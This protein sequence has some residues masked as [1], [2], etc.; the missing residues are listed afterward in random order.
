M[1]EH[2]KRAVRSTLP[3]VIASGDAVVA[4]LCVAST[5][6]AV[7]VL[8][9]VLRLGSPLHHLSER[10]LL[11]LLLW[12]ALAGLSSSIVIGALV[13]VFADSTRRDDIAHRFTLALVPA[14]V[15]T[16]IAFAAT[17]SNRPILIV[18]ALA[19]G[20]TLFCVASRSASQR[21]IAMLA[22]A[23]ATAVLAQVDEIGAGASK[24]IVV[25]GTI[26]LLILWIATSAPRR[27]LAIWTAGACA[28]SLLTVFSAPLLELS[29]PADD[30]P[31]GP[32][33]ILI[34]LDTVRADHLSLYGYGRETTPNLEVFA[35]EATLYRHA[36]AASDTTLST[37]A[38]LFTGMYAARH[39]AHLT[40]RVGDATAAA[41]FNWALA[42]GSRLANEFKTI[43]EYLKQAKI[44]T[45]SIA[46]NHSYVVPEFG[47]AQGF[48]YFC[49]QTPLAR[50]D[51]LPRISPLRLVRDARGDPAA[52]D[53][54]YR[55]AGD[56]LAEA[57][58]VLRIAEATRQRLFLFVNLMDAHTPY[59]PPPPFDRRYP[60][61]IEG[62]TQS[63][64][65]AVEKRVM[66]GGMIR[67][68]EKVHLLSQYDGGIAY[69]DFS[70]GR[71]LKELKR[72]D[73]YDNSLIVITSDHGEAFGDRGLI[74][75]GV[76]VYQ[77]QV[78]VPLIVKFPGISA[79]RVSDETTSSIDV[80]PTI[81][82][83]ATGRVPRHLE[84]KNL[85]EEGV[86]QDR[87]IISESF[88][89]SWWPDIPRV[90]RI[91]RAGVSGP[92]KIIVSSHGDAALYDLRSD[93]NEA[94][95][96]C[97][98]AMPDGSCEVLAQRLLAAVPKELA[99]P[100][101]PRLDEE[102]LRNL[103]SLGYTR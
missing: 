36:F 96:L 62:F 38:S 26:A 45:V 20:A 94:D 28:I 102:T 29:R 22:F 17:K 9:R 91:E 99:A 11:E 33:V 100:R 92:M 95:N 2:L 3:L 64:H 53:P 59:A 35:R 13:C 55:R 83:A 40:G 43:A 98:R 69:L 6:L 82:H 44:W 48:D 72:R 54:P 71:F 67:P 90:Q 47:F 14:A 68:A 31:A 80:M 30:S 27:N 77:D 97:A 75:H 103:Q 87:L 61:K 4:W 15:L 85:N 18:M 8:D 93:P 56:V 52:L 5:N 10:S 88:P 73:L 12:P 50:R 21:R 51:I 1:R 66:H 24:A 49:S 65:T 23:V 86:A 70:I 101:P 19:A 81:L 42:H 60:G 58:R 39:G 25:W 89:C 79:R 74:N 76:S 46:A 32:N 34:V 63:I 78:H 37:H 84:G 57:A 41:K 16:Q 7:V